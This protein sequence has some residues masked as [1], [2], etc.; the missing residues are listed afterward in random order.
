MFLAVQTKYKLI[1]E[2][3]EKYKKTCLSFSKIDRN[4]R[5][6]ITHSFK[7][8]KEIAINNNVIKNNT[9]LHNNTSISNNDFVLEKNKSLGINNSLNKK[10]E[11]GK[12]YIDGKLDL[13]NLTIDNAY[14]RTFNFI[15][16][17]FLNKLKCLLIITGKGLH[18]PTNNTIKNNLTQWF[19]QPF[20][21]N[22]II[23]YTDATKKDGGSGAIYVLLKTN[24]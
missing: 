5:V 18:S 6:A 9:P 11:T 17:A 10:L 13:H 24:K 22:K 23:K 7:N 12:L 16:N 21:A 14:N 20:F 19:K 4:K 15:E 8:F 2:E 3:W 1:M